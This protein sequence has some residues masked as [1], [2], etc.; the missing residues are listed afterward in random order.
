MTTVPLAQLTP[1]PATERPTM[2]HFNAVFTGYCTYK[3]AG[4]VL[5]NLCHLGGIGLFV[6]FI[7]LG[8]VLHLIHQPNV[9]NLVAF[10]LNSIAEIGFVISMAMNVWEQRQLQATLTT[11]EEGGPT[12]T[13]DHDLTLVVVAASAA[14]QFAPRGARRRQPET[15]RKLTECHSSTALR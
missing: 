14:A 5:V 2:R 1:N 8:A 11:A 12:V 3:R 7:S 13:C 10:I 4:F 9:F 6:V 15:T